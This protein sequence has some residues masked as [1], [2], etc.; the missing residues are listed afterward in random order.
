MVKSN[1]SRQQQSVET[2]FM[3]PPLVDIFGYLAE[4]KVAQLVINGTFIAPADTSKYI[5]DFLD[6][7][8]M[9]DA[10]R[11]LGPVNLKISCK[12]NR[13]GWAEMKSC[14][15]LEPTT[16]NFGPCKISSMDQELNKID[17]FLKDITTRLGIDFTSWKIIT[18]FQILKSERRI[19]RRYYKMHT[20]NGYGIQYDEQ[21]RWQTHL[22]TYRKG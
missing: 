1:L 20:T 10:I 14:T 9:L 17:I 15:G 7:L 3:T 2:P 8:V 18:D 11:E 6:T 5:L 22:G 12:D 13:T 4:D 19:S 21:T 16:P